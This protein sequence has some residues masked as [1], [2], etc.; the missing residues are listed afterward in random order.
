MCGLT[1]LC[2]ACVF[3]LVVQH[4][5]KTEQVPL[6][7]THS[8]ALSGIPSLSNCRRSL[9]RPPIG[10]YGGLNIF[11]NGFNIAI[12]SRYKL[13]DVHLYHLPNKQY[14]S[15]LLFATL[16][17]PPSP[18]PSSS[19]PTKQEIGVLVTHFRSGLPSRKISQI[20]STS[21]IVSNRIRPKYPFLPIFMLGDYNLDISLECKQLPSSKLKKEHIPICEEFRST[22]K[23]TLDYSENDKSYFRVEG[24]LMNK[25]KPT[26]HIEVMKIEDECQRKCTSNDF[27]GENDIKKWYREECYKCSVSDHC[28]IGVTL[29]ITGGYVHTSVQLC[30]CL[31]LE[32]TGLCVNAPRP[33][34]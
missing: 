28:P 9:A 2:H 19:H 24:I 22:F 4:A 18:S 23:D 6:A 26:M 27:C 10:S 14:E 17:I 16:K 15:N 11:L 20:K 30:R 21:F 31:R 1:R 34:L 13:H 29:R 8:H 33:H 12:L 25:T 3:V 7:L 32:S 5:S